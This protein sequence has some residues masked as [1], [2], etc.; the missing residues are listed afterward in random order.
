[1]ISN[2]RIT[3]KKIAAEKG[4]VWHSGLDNKFYKLD[5]DVE[6]GK[7]TRDSAVKM[8]AIELKIEKS[9]DKHMKELQYSIK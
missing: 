7:M 1:M 2:L 4:I 6:G 5:K 8:A 3:A 9:Y